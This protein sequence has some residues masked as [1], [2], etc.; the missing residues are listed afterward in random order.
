M[1]DCPIVDADGKQ[2]LW[3]GQYMFYEKWVDAL[4]E[5]EAS[6]TPVARVATMFKDI[7]A[8]LPGDLKFQ[9]IA[10][11]SLMDDLI[12]KALDGALVMGA[13]REEVTELYRRKAW[14]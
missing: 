13:R 7:S 3:T 4:E 1:D 9:D 10:E 11:Y 12:G 2:Q 8:V 6:H 5:K 14:L